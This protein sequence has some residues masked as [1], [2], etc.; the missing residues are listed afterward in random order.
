MTTKSVRWLAAALDDAGWLDAH[1][2]VSIPLDVDNRIGRRASRDFGVNINDSSQILV[3]DRLVFERLSELPERTQLNDLAIS[4]LHVD[5]F[6]IIERR[7]TCSRK[8]QFNPKRFDFMWQMQHGCFVAA[9][10]RR[11]RVG[12][13]LRRD[14]RQCRFGFVGFKHETNL[15]V[16]RANVQVDHAGFVFQSIA[17]RCERLRSAARSFPPA[18]RRL[19]P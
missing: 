2:S 1:W 7:S 8:L 15:I 3:I 19:P 5:F 6:Q 17:R 13:R 11:D 12:D 9:E 16:L 18:D 4:P 10:N 14:S